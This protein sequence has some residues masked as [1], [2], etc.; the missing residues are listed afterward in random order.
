MLHNFGSYYCFW[1]LTKLQE[2]RP[3][4]PKRLTPFSSVK[5]IFTMCASLLSASIFTSLEM[6][7]H[8]QSTWS[9][10]GILGAT[11]PFLYTSKKIIEQTDVLNSPEHKN[12]SKLAW[13]VSLTQIENKK[14]R[15]K[16]KHMLFLRALS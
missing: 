12:T 4:S 9:C 13:L 10:T 6:W 7:Q 16:R 11:Q 5:L 15:H 8:S 3:E 1:N 14:N 2:T